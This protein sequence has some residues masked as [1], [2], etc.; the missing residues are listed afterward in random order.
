MG[1]K[2]VEEKQ[3]ESRQMLNPLLLG[4]QKELEKLKFEQNA[5]AS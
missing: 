5:K 3:F 4:E 2:G 1:N